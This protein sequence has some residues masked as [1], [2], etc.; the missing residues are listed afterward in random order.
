LP[1]RLLLAK[2]V[3]GTPTADEEPYS[4]PLPISGH[5]TV[6]EQPESTIEAKERCFHTRFKSIRTS[7]QIHQLLFEN[8]AR[9]LISGPFRSNFGKRITG[10]TKGAK[11]PSKKKV[12][13][14]GDLAEDQC[15]LTPNSEQ[16]E[17]V[18]VKVN[19]VIF[20]PVSDAMVKIER[21]FLLPVTF[22]LVPSI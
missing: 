8:G 5:V 6:C 15:S 20:W 9:T 19:D 13:S 2:V 21:T 22:V 16:P 4:R 1:V 14:P 3:R 10:S 7:L 11:A 18:V 12:R 17:A